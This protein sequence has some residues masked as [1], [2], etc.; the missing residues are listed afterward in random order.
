MGYSMSNPR[1]LDLAYTLDTID[2]HRDAIF[3]DFVSNLSS[4]K[5]VKDEVIQLDKFDE[6]CLI[7]VDKIKECVSGCVWD[8]DRIYAIYAIEVKDLYCVLRI[9]NNYRLRIFN[10]IRR[11]VELGQNIYGKNEFVQ[12][13]KLNEL[14]TILLDKIKEFPYGC[15]DKDLR[16][17]LQ[18]ISACRSSIFDNIRYI[19]LCFCETIYKQSI[20]IVD[21]RNLLEKIDY[22]CLDLADKIKKSLFESIRFP[23]LPY[24]NQTVNATTTSNSNV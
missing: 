17:N 11:Y 22:L 15:K 20:K 13:D 24:G 8:K 1:I 5:D 19:D 12:L 10:N 21:E 4:N 9:V 14:Y 6:L 16:D 7:L 3:S 18:I 2:K 23:D